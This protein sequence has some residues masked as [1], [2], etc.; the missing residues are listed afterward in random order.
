M[1]K[2]FKAPGNGCNCQLKLPKETL[3]TVAHHLQKILFCW[4]HE[5][6]SQDPFIVILEGLAEIVSVE[7]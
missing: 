6:N 7:G 3:F 1:L 2:H 4:F 5:Q